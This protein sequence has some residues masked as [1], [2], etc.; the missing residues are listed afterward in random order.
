MISVQK[1][2][3]TFEPTLE[4]SEKMEEQF[5]QTVFKTLKT[6]SEI[7][8]IN[9]LKTIKYNDHSTKHD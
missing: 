7:L 8:K 6:M 3:E 1:I 5:C 9:Q 4:I 2:T